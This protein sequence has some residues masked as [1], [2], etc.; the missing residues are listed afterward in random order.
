MCK[1]FEATFGIFCFCAITGGNFLLK[2]IIGE[3]LFVL[4]LIA[5]WLYARRKYNREMEEERKHDEEFQRFLDE[6]NEEIMKSLNK[7]CQ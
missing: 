3:S 4:I 1:Y 2:F 7:P 5:A 6:M